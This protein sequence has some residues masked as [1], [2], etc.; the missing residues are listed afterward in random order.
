[1]SHLKC[2]VAAAAA[3]ILIADVGHAQ[4]ATALTVGARVRF[5]SSKPVPTPLQVVA[6][7]GDSLALQT[8]NGDTLRLG[9]VDASG[10]QISRGI[11]QRK[12]KGAMMG[13]LIGVA[14]GAVAGAVTYEEP[15][16]A[17][18]A[19]I[20]PIVDPGRGGAAAI[21][22]ALGGL[23]GAVVGVIV[24]AMSPAERWGPISAR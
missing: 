15:R 20:C 10:L 1:M 19:W 6:L 16:C 21:V 14:V 17:P 12:L 5:V 2:M 7:A 9:L 23:S 8:A 13:L 22:G 3:V 18:E 11:H 24:G 4:R